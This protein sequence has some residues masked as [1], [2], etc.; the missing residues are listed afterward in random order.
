[1]HKTSAQLFDGD[2]EVMN[3]DSPHLKVNDAFARRLQHNKQ[4]EELHRLQ[5]RHPKEAA[6]AAQC[7]SAQQPSEE[8][9]SS[10]EDEDDGYIPNAV[11]KQIF[12]TMLKIRNRDSSIY[13]SKKHF[14]ADAS[15]DDQPRQDGKATMKSKASKPMLLKDVIAQQ[16]LEHG[17]EAADSD[18]EEAEPAEPTYIQEQQDLKRNFLQAR[19]TA[20]KEEEKDGSGDDFGGG[21]LHKRQ[22]AGAQDE[23]SDGEAADLQQS[24]DEYFGTD[25]PLNNDDRFLRQYVLNKGWVDAD[26]AGL[27]SYEEIVGVHDDED[28]AYDEQADHFEAAY[29]F[30]F[31]EE[32]GRQMITH[33]RILE[34]TVR[35]TDDRRKRKRAEKAQRKAAQE[36]IQQQEVKRLKNL[37]GQQIQ[38][39]DIAGPSGQDD[40]ALDAL[41]QGDFDPEQYDKQMAAAFGDVYYGDED[42]GPGDILDDELQR[43]LNEMADYDS[44]NEE[45]PVIAG[46][47]AEEPKA[48]DSEEDAGAAA[49]ALALERSAVNKLLAEY[50]KLDYED[51]IGGLKTRFH[52]RTVAKED[53]GLST[54]EILRLKDKELNQLVGL[55]QMAPY[56]E[57]RG[58]FRPNYGKMKEL[59]IGQEQKQAKWQQRQRQRQEQKARSK[60][61]PPA[62]DAIVTAQAPAADGLPAKKAPADAKAQRM[63]SFQKLTL[64]RS[65]P[66]GSN[67][68]LTGVT[69]KVAAPAPMSQSD[70]AAAGLSKA[71]RKNMKRAA[72]RASKR[73]QNDLK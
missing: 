62:A 71:A 43:Q 32:G 13:D 5:E 56:R 26:E 65:K 61:K 48:E 2:D 12:E 51:D 39:R 55:K 59:Q 38:E 17:A 7:V 20:V 10:E 49:A 35:K 63:K 47:S 64:K 46:H 27:P 1:M 40:A 15:D 44:A 23:Q 3:V 67:H 50:D 16:A 57:A 41:M 25:A 72:K 33:P 19:H 45:D 31:E 29:N 60:Q 30:R 24:L 8:E 42:D 11:E 68:D 21:V 70:S 9:G 73:A 22:R 52:Y 37:K 28:E 53:Y 54:D 4:R 18:E 36:S 14:F 69:K 66:S 58:K 6:K 34:N